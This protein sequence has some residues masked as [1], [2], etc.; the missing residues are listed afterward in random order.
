L[1]YINYQQTE[2]LLR[3]Y[4]AMVKQV[5]QL[6]LSMEQICIN[7]MDERI[8]SLVVGNKVLND[9]P[10]PPVGN[11]SDK[12]AKV[13][14]TYKEALKNTDNKAVTDIIKEMILVENTVK[15]IDLAYEDLPFFW[16][17]VIEGKYFVEPPK[18]WAEIAKDCR[19][20][21]DKRTLQTYRKNAVEKIQRSMRMTELVYFDVI[22][23]M[24]HDED[25]LTESL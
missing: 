23:L 19:K 3:L 7:D 12:T 18:T 2:E 10:F 6:A 22:Q 14:M 16:K 5:E 4:P 1:N 15:K 8:Y 17:K 13:A 11:T 9:M 20:K 24:K 21:F 25:N